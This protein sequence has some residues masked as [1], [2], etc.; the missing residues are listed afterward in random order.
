MAGRLPAR[1]WGWSATRLPTCSMD[2]SATR[3]VMSS[4]VEM[5]K[6][7]GMQVTAEG[8]ETELQASLA[9][10][11]GCD[12]MQGWLYSKA[13]PAVELER[14]LAAQDEQLAKIEQLPLRPSAAKKLG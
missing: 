9:R 8:I 2:D 10:N 12:Q 7:L 6:A 13:V 14:Q 5:A 3:T 1:C 11:A 4:S